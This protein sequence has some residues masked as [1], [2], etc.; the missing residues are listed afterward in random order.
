MIWYDT[1]NITK[2]CFVCLMPCKAKA[3][4][5]K[6]LSKKRCLDQEGANSENGALMMPQI[7]LAYWTGLRVF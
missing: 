5:I 6:I 7:Y 4:N 2:L 3:Q 1:E